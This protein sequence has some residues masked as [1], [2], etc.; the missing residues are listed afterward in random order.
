M[1]PAARSHCNVTSTLGLLLGTRAPILG[2]E[3]QTKKGAFPE[4]RHPPTHPLAPMGPLLRTTCVCGPLLLETTLLHQ[5]KRIRAVH[6][7]VLMTDEVAK[8]RA[9]QSPL[10]AAQFSPALIPFLPFLP[11]SLHPL[12]HPSLQKLS[13]TLSTHQW[14][15][16]CR[17]TLLSAASHSP[18]CNIVTS[19]VPTKEN[20]EVA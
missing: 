4:W 11:S 10:H 20:E 6:C 18:V 7:S 9:R 19:M 17:Q 2:K 14:D 5:G 13:A 1:H 12:S 3:G 16:S 15:K 8:W